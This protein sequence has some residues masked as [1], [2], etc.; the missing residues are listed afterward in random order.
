MLSPIT[1]GLLSFLFLL[2]FVGYRSA[3]DN[4]SCPFFVPHMN[5]RTHCTVQGL[6]TILFESFASAYRDAVHKQL[7]ADADRVCV[8][9]ASKIFACAVIRNPYGQCPIYNIV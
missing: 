2:L 5:R 7:A 9:Y 1:S 4:E 3:H 6:F 8:C